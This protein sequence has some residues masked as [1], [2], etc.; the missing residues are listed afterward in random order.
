MYVFLTGVPVKPFIMQERS[1][2]QL[3]DFN[4]QNDPEAARTGRY[5]F[6]ANQR[7]GFGV[8]LPLAGIK[9]TAS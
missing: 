8:G 1:P 6:V 7:L 4:E 3:W 5:S 2:I 9:L